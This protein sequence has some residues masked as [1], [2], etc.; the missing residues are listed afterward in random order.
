MSGTTAKPDTLEQEIFPEKDRENLNLE[1]LADSKKGGANAPPFVS[2]LNFIQSDN[3]A[4]RDKT[5][6]F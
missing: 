6:L 2:R 5:R 1:G 3:R 4:D